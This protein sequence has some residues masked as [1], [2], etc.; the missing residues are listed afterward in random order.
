MDTTLRKCDLDD[1]MAIKA[2]GMQ[3]YEDTF[4]A[5]NT[6][7]NMQAYLDSA[8]NTEQLEGELSNPDSTFFFLFV[9]KHLAGYMKL[10]EAEAQSDL[11]DP[12]ALEIERIYIKK[13]FQGH[14]LG[15]TLMQ[16]ALQIAR[17][18]KKQYA[19]LGVWEL[20]TNAIAF[21]EKMGFYKAGTHGFVM[22]DDH[23]TDFIMKIIL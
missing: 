22:G 1:L 21:Y 7:E 6:P 15:K 9:D 4:R 14:G 10:N 5:L 18:K 13:E 17:E 2:I 16:H 3:T 20:N 23:Q 19:W 8:F 12:V 11:K